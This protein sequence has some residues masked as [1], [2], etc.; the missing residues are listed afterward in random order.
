[1][2]S[3]RKHAPKKQNSRATRHDVALLAGVSDAVVSY[4]LNGHAPVAAETASRVRDAVEKLHYQPNQ[5]ARALKSG[6]AKALALVSPSGED[7]VFGNPFLGQFA[8]AVI[9]KARG[10]GYALYV[11]SADDGP[12]GVRDVASAFVVRQ[13]DGIL[14]LSRDGDFR[15]SLDTLGIPW[16]Q[17]NATNPPEDTLSVGVDEYEGGVAVTEH[18]IGHGYRRIAFIGEG[19]GEPRHDAWD[20]TCRSR[21]ITPIFLAVGSYSHAAGYE[22]GLKLADSTDRPTAVF[23]ASDMLAVGLLQGLH[24]RQIRVPDQMAV[25]SFDGSWEGRFASSPLTSFSQPIDTMAEA[26]IRKLLSEDQ[27]AAHETF[28]G[29][30]IIRSSCGCQ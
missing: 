4:T 25:A 26:A 24:E 19:P 9:D 5:A 23:A 13:V 20:A 8:S 21:G 28:P 6:S 17:L 16:V 18:L 10:L 3:P 11:A 27:S 30:L 2:T 1:M 22:A 14:L 12:Q 7:G 15:L 29:E